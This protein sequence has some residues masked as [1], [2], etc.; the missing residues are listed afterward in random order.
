MANQSVS[1][2]DANAPRGVPVRSNG[3]SMSA[4]SAAFGLVIA[5]ATV[6]TSSFCIMVIELV[7]GRLIAPYVGSSLY[8]WT[9][10][11]GVVLAGI[12]GGNYLG[13]RVADRYAKDSRGA[14]RTLAGLFGLAGVVA[15]GIGLF[16]RIVGSMPFLEGMD[17]LK[18]R[19]AL[20]V[21]LVFF[22]PC[23]MLGLISPV[24]AKSA[25]D[26]GRRTGRTM[27]SV[28]AWGVVGSIV[29]TFMTGFYFIAV[30]NTSTIILSVG[31]LLLAVA[32]MYGAASMSRTTK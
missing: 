9:S 29:G 32:A 8:T 13:G 14:R 19:I 5:N 20:H 31:C 28:Y 6:F 3:G 10:I 15:L 17:S 26:L 24:V 22:I 2:S 12:A 21:V 11:I 25:L 1:V 23:G 4:S 7:A 18:L 16:N 30:M 27:G